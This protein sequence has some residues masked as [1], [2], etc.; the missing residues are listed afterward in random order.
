MF[1]IQSDHKPP[2]NGHSEKPNSCTS[3]EERPASEQLESLQLEKTRAEL[4]ILKAYLKKKQSEEDATN[5]KR[6]S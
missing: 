1:Q 3:E 2:L 4:K 6:S 5:L